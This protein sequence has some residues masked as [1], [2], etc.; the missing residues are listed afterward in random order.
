MTRGADGAVACDDGRRLLSVPAHPG[1]VVDTT[2]A[3]DLFT[4][5]YVWADLADAPLE[6]RLRWAVLYSGL[7]VGVPTAV[8]GAVTLQDLAKA[9]AGLGLELRSELTS[10]VSRRDRT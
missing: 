2:G 8:A 9:G 6:E 5:A 7:A 4:A 3:G 1:P 10:M